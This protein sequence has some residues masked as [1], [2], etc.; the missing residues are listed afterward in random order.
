M[1]PVDNPQLTL[2]YNFAEHTGIHIFLTG[3]AGTGKTTFLRHLKNSS[4]KRMVIVAPTG[5]AAINAGGVTIHSFFQMPFG[6][7]LPSDGSDQNNSTPR[8][9][10]QRMS[11]E[12][13]N[14]I[15][16]IDL[17][18]IDE[19]SMVRADLLDGI[20]ETLRR[21][22]NRYKPFGGVQLLMIGDLQQLAPVAKED[23]WAILRKYYD[24]PFF[25]SSRAL[26][27]TNYVTIELKH[28]YRQSDPVFINLLNKIRDNDPDPETF[29]ELNKRFIPGFSLKAEDGYITLTTHNYQAQELNESKL[30]QLS[31]VKYA[32]RANLEGEFPEY[33]YPT[34]LDLVVKIGAQVMFVKNDISREKLF[35][36]GKVGKIQNIE[37]DIIYV[38]CS[39]DLEPIPVSRMEWENNKY[40]IDE[41]TKEIKET[42]VGKFIQYPLKLAW[43]ITIHK[44]Q[45]L[46]FEKAIIDA[47]SSFAHGQVYV[48]LS[49]CKTLEGLVLSTPISFNSIKTDS[50]V[51]QFNR[52]AEAN[53]PDEERLKKEKLEYQQSLLM[54][55]IDFSGLQ[56]RLSYILKLTEEHRPNLHL[57]VID[58]FTTMNN[59]VKAE[60]ADV[61]V[62]FAN[63]IKQ[64]FEPQEDLED[65]QALQERIKKGCIWFEEKLI[66]ISEP[67]N[68]TA[69]DIDNKVIRKSVN[70]A[71][72]RL[73]EELS[74]KL[75]CLRTCKHGFRVKDYLEARAKSSIEMPESKSAKKHEVFTPGNVVHP[76]LYNALKSWRQAKAEE[77]GLPVYMILPQKALM[78]VVAVL[79]SN[80]RELERVK[81]FGK[82][83]VKQFGNELLQIIRD[84][85]K[86][87]NS[88]EAPA[89]AE[90]QTD[91][92]EYSG[93][94]EPKINTK[95]KT[96]SLFRQGKTVLEIAAERNM[97]P[98]TIENHIAQYVGMG[99]ININELV[100]EEKVTKISEYFL[101]ADSRLLAPAK[102]AFGDAVEWGELRYV[103]KYMEYKNPGQ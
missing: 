31:G 93:S 32:F 50:T 15:K 7:Y 58:M 88:G 60:L 57:S 28:I 97:A 39:G 36:N 14:I 1:N 80:P 48:A 72:S 47:K 94:E 6:P 8:Q 61:S 87:Q 83:K 95:E 24:N 102:A 4:P 29:H 18:V 35:Y 54:E 17:L 100:T 56:R 26:K 42:L 92:L 96:L 77:A 20:D 101:N 75:S 33:S 52:N 53:S 25:F 64:I 103:L 41:E 86:G 81:G 90:E 49:R 19:I 71:I 51:S 66:L 78:D 40:S 46:T 16:S 59:A 79:P 69:I 76:K 13:I 2:A 73:R 38:L 23:E 43:A 9:G 63:Q 82:K 62:K 5:V 22:R 27:Q 3:K 99:E 84:Y 89:E 11:R 21:Y 34:D 45:G 85:K 37:D 30:Q 98:A 10:F 44:S 12:K 68:K 74:I 55:L 65:N 67:L 70:D 91:N